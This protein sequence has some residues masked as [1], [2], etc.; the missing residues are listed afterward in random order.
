[1][2]KMTNISLFLPVLLII[3]MG[4]A[5]AEKKPLSDLESQIID[6]SYQKMKKSIH[7]LNKKIGVCS[8]QAKKMR[9]NPATI[10]LPSL[11][12]KEL[13]ITLLYF[14]FYAEHK[15]Q[16][17]ENWARATQSFTQFKYIEKKLTGKN[18]DTI[19]NNH[20]Y[21]LNQLCCENEIYYLEARQKYLN[22]PLSTRTELEKILELQ[23]PFDV[24]QALET[25][26]AL[27]KTT[28]QTGE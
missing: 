14:A 25:F 22:L 12:P 8:T 7:Q 13:K 15:C 3:M 23:K 10:R 6:L 17:A 11:T 18:T 26:D 4:S 19:I 24:F 28:P 16:G 20:I 1:M 21:T 2:F 27:S 5:W 9:L